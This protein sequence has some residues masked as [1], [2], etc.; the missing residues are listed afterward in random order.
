MSTDRTERE[1][2]NGLDRFLFRRRMG[3]IREFVPRDCVLLDVG[4]GYHFE[5]LK[6]FR[7]RLRAG[8]GADLQVPDL[9]V[10][11]LQVPPIELFRLDLGHDDF[12]LPEG[13][14]DVVTFLAVIE[15][16]DDPGPV[17]GEIRRVLMP[18]GTLLL[19]TPTPPAQPILASL[20]HTGLLRNR[21]ALDHKILYTR[22]RL[23]AVLENSGL[24]LVEHRYFQFGLNQF[25]RAEKIGKP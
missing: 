3:R 14:V 23:A 19:T 5:L 24:R 9:Q 4:C 21:D 13:S 2:W 6:H 25:G 1:P 8:Y 15:H 18:R 7:N 12:P 16:L 20:C 17:L 11:D 22:A 10:P